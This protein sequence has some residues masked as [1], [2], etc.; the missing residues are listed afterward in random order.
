MVKAYIAI[1]IAGVFGEI[2]IE[3]RLKKNNIDL[4]FEASVRNPI[5]IALKALMSL[6]LCF[7]SLT[8][9]LFGFAVIPL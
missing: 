4:G 2:R 6:E 3:K 1:I 9:K 7:A 5:L 8:F